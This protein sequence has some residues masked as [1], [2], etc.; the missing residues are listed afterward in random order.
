MTSHAA[1]VGLF[2]S[3]HHW[4]GQSDDWDLEA[5]WAELRTLYPVS[6]TIDEVLSEAGTR[7]RL[8]AEAD[9][10]RAEERAK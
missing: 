6:I 3:P 2:A 7:G 5:L 1:G 4:E 8:S 9:M 10:A